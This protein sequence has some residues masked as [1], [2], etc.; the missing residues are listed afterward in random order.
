MSLSDMKLAREHPWPKKL[1]LSFGDAE[2]LESLLA[3]YIRKSG[4][5]GGKH[6]DGIYAR[7]RSLLGDLHDRPVQHKSN[8]SEGS[9][10]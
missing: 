5:P 9:V 2:F 10:G 3:D 4:G 6:S 1:S 8:L 7:V